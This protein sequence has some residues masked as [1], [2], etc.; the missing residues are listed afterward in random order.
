M[1]SKGTSQQ[2]TLLQTRVVLGKQLNSFVKSWS[3]YVPVAPG[4]LALRRRIVYLP[5]C[6]P[7][8]DDPDRVPLVHTENTD[9]CLKFSKKPP[10][11]YAKKG[12]E[13]RL[14]RG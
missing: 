6:P 8:I 10:P 12:A 2:E 5:A 14:R 4:L 3:L 9:I 11:V 1:V 13:G 7:P